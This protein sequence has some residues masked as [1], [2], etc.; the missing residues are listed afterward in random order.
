MTVRWK[1]EADHL[2]GDALRNRKLETNATEQRRR[3]AEITQTMRT[4]RMKPSDFMTTTLVTW[5]K[6]SLAC[7]S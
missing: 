7:F 6:R 4:R 5:R 1:K 3:T 2:D